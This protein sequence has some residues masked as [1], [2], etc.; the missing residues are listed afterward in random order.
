[1]HVDRVPQF[2][3]V[4]LAESKGAAGLAIA[5]RPA[6][7]L[8][9]RLAAMDG[10][11]DLEHIQLVELQRAAGGRRELLAERGHLLRRDRGVRDGGDQDGMRRCRLRAGAVKS[12]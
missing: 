12:A 6:R 7:R 9:L 3:A 5:A 4:R 8:D 1:M 2:A 11:G 10:D